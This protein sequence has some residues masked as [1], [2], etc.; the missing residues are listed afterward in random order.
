RDR[1]RVVDAGE[2]R[3][4]DEETARAVRPAAAKDQ[5]SSLL[6]ARRDV[7]LDALALDLADERADED[8]RIGGI[9]HREPGDLLSERPPHPALARARRQ[10]PGLVRAGLPVVAHRVG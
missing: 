4:L 8:F 9:A 3:R 6:A 10:H 5:P 2:E 7:T 1:H